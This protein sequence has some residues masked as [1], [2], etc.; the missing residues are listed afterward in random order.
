MKKFLLPFFLFFIVSIN[1]QSL[2]LNENFD[3]GSTINPDLVALTSNWVRHSGAMGPAYSNTSLTYPGYPSSG[4]G[5]SLTFLN[6]SSGTN[7]GDIHRSF[8]SIAT[9][10]NVYTSFLLNL[11]SAM[12]TAD[13]FFHLGQKTIGT[14]F[15]GRVFARANAPGWS[16][17]F[18]KSSETRTDDNT[19]LNFNQTYLV[20]VKIAF[21]TAAADDDLVT[22]YLYDT[23]LPL[24][25][26]GSPLVTIGPLGA[27]VTSDLANFGSVAIRQGSNSP[28]GTV[29]GIR[30]S[31]VWDALVP[32]ELT[33]FV[34]S[35]NGKTVNLNWTTATEINNAGFEVER[36]YINASWQKIGFVNGN[37]TTS[38]KQSYAFTD[39]NLSDGKYSYRL[40]QVDFNGAFEYSTVVEVEVVTPNRFELSQN[41][42]NPFN[43][44][45]AIKF[46]L[47]NAGN[48]K[49]AI[50]NLLGQE[51]QTL[52]NGYMESGS[53]TVNFNAKNL[54][55]GIYLY[56]LEANSITSVKKM[57]FLK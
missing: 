47:P 7:D 56:K 15:R 8:D 35:I 36:K 6:G 54:N 37:G 16:L 25:E 26:P 23:G 24:V 46:D 49:L 22:I 11:S 31:T 45:T 5:G 41:Y 32:V 53:H 1:S 20:I 29:D 10:Q 34:G 17:G 14:T 21:S 28:T 33:S 9:T 50:Y 39:K 38:E 40:K 3:Y 48:V 13:Y 27:G 12:A 30:V 2:K 44:T 19:I 18:S 57:T 51:I 42:P 52:I 43:P 55:S 4:I